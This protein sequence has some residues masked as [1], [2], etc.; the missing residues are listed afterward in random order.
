MS[1][2]GWWT[3]CAWLQSDEGSALTVAE[4]NAKICR[5]WHKVHKTYLFKTIYNYTDKN[6]THFVHGLVYPAFSTSH[7]RLF[8]IT[9]W[10]SL[11]LGL[12]WDDL[13]ASSRRAEASEETPTL[14][15][16]FTT[17]SDSFFFSVSSM[18]LPNCWCLQK[19]PPRAARHT[20]ESQQP[21]GQTAF[22]GVRVTHSSQPPKQ[23]FVFYF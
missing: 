18:L 17:E 20:T 5:I 8:S 1:A 19:F 10:K 12:D 22:L 3:A 11:S 13:T 23:L 7:C 21:P 4:G 2:V 9:F 15:A 16:L 6:R 14:S